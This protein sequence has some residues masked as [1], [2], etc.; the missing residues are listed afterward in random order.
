MLLL[1]QTWLRYRDFPAYQ[2]PT[3]WVHPGYREWLGNPV[4]Q[5]VA[6][7]MVRRWFL[8]CIS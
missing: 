5:G 7:G 4:D 1:L 8:L 2:V 6:K 3:G